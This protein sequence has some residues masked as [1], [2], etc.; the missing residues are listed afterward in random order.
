MTLLITG[1]TGF[2]GRNLLLE[3]IASKKYAAI[4]VPVRSIAKLKSQFTEDGFNEIPAVV[5]PLEGSASSWNLG[6]AARCDHVV[7]SAG[8]IFARSWEEYFDTNV[9]GTTRLFAALSPHCKIVVL[10]SLA[11]A[12]P[13]ERN[14]P[15]NESQVEAPLTW[16][17]KSK[18]E[19]EKRLAAEFS[20]RTY[21]CLRPPM[22]FG[23]RDH[24]TLPLFRMMH[25]WVHFK[26]GFRDK[27]FSILA[28]E[29]L[30]SAIFAALEG[31]FVKGGRAYFVAHGR[32][33]T[34]RDILREAARVSGKVSR[35]VMVP[36]W[37]LKIASRLIDTIPTWRTTIPTLSV[38]RAKEIWPDAWVV[39][40]RAFETQFHW[41]A[42]T[43]FPTSME[44][45]REWYVKSGQL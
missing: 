45:T 19:M 22:I 18:L 31:S 1:A 36:Q 43:P 27:E 8:V 10:S 5:R 42:K 33:I 9:L 16:Y 7:H 20:E 4:Y 13:S 28:V 17:G 23:P 29:D 44:R 39:D 12:G 21:L 30:C 32:T 11:A 14:I 6:E 26:P 41:E 35:V 2:V 24:A 25:K 37:V 15:R 3:A 40:S 38:D 34:D